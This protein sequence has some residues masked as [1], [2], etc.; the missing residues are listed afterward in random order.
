M[1]DNKP[2]RV[3]SRSEKVG[4]KRKANTVYNILLAVVIIAIIGVGASIFLG[5]DDKR[6]ASPN[7]NGAQQDNDKIKEDEQKE[8]SSKEDEDTDAKTEGSTDEEDVTD[9]EN[10]ED[11]N[12]DEEVVEEEPTVVENSGDSNVQQTLVN[13][14]WQPIGT[15]QSGEHVADYTKGSV[16]WNEMEKALAYGAGIDENN[17][18]VWFL[19]NGGSP[20]K[21]IG[22]VGPKDKS[23]TYRVYLEW[24]DGGGWKP[25]KV[26]Q[27][28]KNDKGR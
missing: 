8:N 7:D 17:M 12:V 10:N 18:T 13:D 25:T 3:A 24:V 9:E 28:K 21:A 16:D 2:S 22:T 27:L 5:D 15:Q 4:K 26:E 14:S 6:Q 11:E 19:G 20:N 23:A 1:R